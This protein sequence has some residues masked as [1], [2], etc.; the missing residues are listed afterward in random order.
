MK[1]LHN[2][3]IHTLDA[4]TPTASVLVIDR[5]RIIAVGGAEL[6]EQFPIAE[7]V[8]L[9]GRFVLPGL[10]DA[11]IHMQWYSLGLQKV[12]CE[13][14]TREECLRRVAER[15]GVTPPGGWILG[16]GWQQNDWGGEFPSAAHL[17]ATAPD[18]PVYLTAKSLHAGWANS[19]ALKLAGIT[20][21][22]VNPEN[23]KILHDVNGN[24]N[25]ILLETAMDLLNDILPAIQ[26][27]I[28]QVKIDIVGRELWRIKDQTAYAGVEFHEDVPDILPSF[29]Q[30]D[31]LVVPLRYGAG[32]RIKILEAMAAGLPVVSTSKGCEGLAV[33]HG[34][35]LMIADS[36]D[37]FASAV[38]RVMED[39]EL[40]TSISR[41]ARRLVE[42]RYSWEGL[43]GEMAKRFSGVTLQSAERKGYKT[44]ANR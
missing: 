18:H 33:R 8:D 19:A 35:H 26:A 9:G 25:G 3:H 21:A 11:H 32:T 17:D 15:A 1:I 10:T 22:T 38:K 13:T 5:E 30:A 28:P 39:D 29:R 23:G 4:S 6:L 2:A 43:V 31:A 42:E 27:R 16:H 44:N 7:E 34:E 37:E 24:P 36:P 14:G 41:N 20:A 12:D 40:R